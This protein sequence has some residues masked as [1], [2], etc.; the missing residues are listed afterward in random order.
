[1][2]LKD[3]DNL[4]SGVFI[5]FSGN[6][7]KALNFYQRCFGGI[8]HLETFD[9]ELYRDP[10]RPIIIGS[11][12][13]DRIIIHGSDLVHDKGRKIGN[14]L[15]IFLPCANEQD[16]Q[17]LVEKLESPENVKFSTSH[18]ERKLVEVTDP[19]D[20]SWVLSI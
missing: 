13:S 2:L 14:H 10:K 18:K 17:E 20:V 12:V 15:S 1:M 9:E 6:C 16:R 3:R 11:L 4:T 5:T 19:F 8:L 7:K